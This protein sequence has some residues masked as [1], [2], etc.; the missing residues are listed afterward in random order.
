MGSDSN[1]QF[2]LE[3]VAVPGKY[4]LDKPGQTYTCGRGKDNEIVCL[5][6]TVSR[7]HCMFFHTKDEVYVTDLESSNGVYINGVAAKPLQ[8]TKLQ[9]NDIIGIGCATVNV[10]DSS[11]FVYKLRAIS[12]SIENNDSICT[13]SETESNVEKV[14]DDKHNGVLKR[15]WKQENLDTKVPQSKIPKLDCENCVPGQQ[16]LEG[17]CKSKDENDI[18][19]IH[20]S[21]NNS[22][23]NHSD[24]SC[25]NF[26]SHIKSNSKTNINKHMDTTT[27]ETSN[28]TKIAKMNDNSFDSMR[29]PVSNVLRENV[30]IDE[31]SNTDSNTKESN[32]YT[33][34]EVLKRPK[35]KLSNTISVQNK[36]SNVCNFESKST[37][38]NNNVKAETS[39]GT[40]HNSQKQTVENTNDTVIPVNESEAVIDKKTNSLPLSPNFICTEDNI[41]KMEEELQ[42]TDN[43]ENAIINPQ[44]LNSLPIISPI[45]LKKV[46]EQPKTTF[47]VDD[48]V[49]LSDSEDDIFPCSQLF[50]AGYGINTSVK[51]EI[52]EEPI[53]IENERFSI[54]ESADLVI[55]LTDSEDEDNNWLQR[56]SRSQI[57]N[58]DDEIDAE[59]CDIKKEVTDVNDLI[60]NESP[61][62]EE[63]KCDIDEEKEKGKEPE[64]SAHQKECITLPSDKNLS[65]IFLPNVSV[66]RI[67]LDFRYCVNKLAET[68]D[69]VSATTE[70]R[71]ESP[72]NQSFVQKE[73][74]SATSSN[75]EK[76]V[77]SKSKKLEKKVP[78]IEPLHMPTGRRRSSWN[79]TEEVSKKSE[80]SSKSEGSTKPPQRRLSVQE[81][82][83]EQEKLKLE[84]YLHTKEQKNRKMLH[85]WAACLPPS[86]KKPSAPLSKEEK[87][88][89]VDNRKVKLKKLAM[90]KRLSLEDNQGKKRV[91]SKPKAKVTTKTRND[92]LVEE[93][94]SA[95]K[96]DDTTEM[97]KASSSK[98]ITTQNASANV[99]L[100]ASGKSKDASME[101]IKRLQNKLT[102]NDISTL[103]KIPKKSKAKKSDANT[104]VAE[105]ALK[106]LSLEK[107]TK[108][109]NKSNKDESKIKSGPSLASNQKLSNAETKTK[110][111]VSFS[112]TIQTVHVYEI[113]E[114]NVLKKLVGKDAPIPREKVMVTKPAAIAKS[115]NAKYNEF[116]LRIFLWNPVWLEEQMHLKTIAPVVNPDELHLML[117]HY[118]SYDEYYNTIAPLLL[119][120][121][122]YCI[123]KDFQAVDSNRQ[124]TLMCSTVE[125]SVQKEVASPNLHFT[126]LMLEVLATDEDMHKQAHPLFGD[127]VFFEC[128]YNNNKGQAFRKVFAF[129]LDLH[130]TVLTPTTRFNKDLLHYVNKPRTLLTYTMRTRPL[131]INILVNRVQRLRVVTYL[132]PNLRM[133]QALDYLPSSPLMN[134]ILNP[135]LEMYQLPVISESEALI[136]GD[137]LN[138]KQMEAVCKVTKTVVQRDTKLCFIHGPPGTGK[139]KV[140]VNIITQILYGNNRYTSNGSSFKMLVCAPSNAA[141]DEIV[142]RLLN[143]RSSIK[144]DAKLKPFRMVR[145]GRPETMHPTVKDI[146]VTELARRDIRKTTTNSNNISPESIQDEMQF[147]ISKINAIKCELST[148]RNVDEVYK[149]HLK[150]KLDE[151]TLKYEMLRNPRPLNERNDKERMKLQRNAENRILGHADIITCTLSSCCTNQ[152]ESIFGTNKKRISVCI[153]DEA[154]Q[155]CEAETLIPLMLGINTFVLVG[156]HNQLPATILSPEAKKNGLDQSIFSRVQRAFESQ[157]HNPIITLDVQYRMHKD[158]AFWPNKFFY[159]G[160][161]KNEVRCD[162]NFP[163]HAYRMLNMNTNQSNDSFSNDN[164][165]EFVANI[166]YSMFTFANFDKWDSCISYGILTPYNNQKAIIL[167]KIN[168]K[169]SSVPETI[170]KK[171]KIEINT[172]DGFQGQERDVIIMSCVR[173]E[174]I[175]FLADRQRLCVALTRAKHSLIICGNFGIFMG[176]DMEFVV[177]RRKNPPDLF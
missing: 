102:I 87:K 116:L 113:D 91:L 158:I 160:Q 38:Q 141:I 10:T 64:Q 171:M 110:K 48:V 155:S 114:S 69:T 163:F 42:L 150:I 165:A 143:I 14:C 25:A 41:I 111:R 71:L 47:S 17:R 11:M 129:V 70:N 126:T 94:I 79:K 92:F 66:E 156:D 29:P 57:L 153:V 109:T 152:M 154:T 2:V 62:R 26:A 123:T 61:L 139:S 31:I 121:I 68:F 85:K 77:P 119:L 168:E 149:Q 39:L 34:Q 130:I 50:D 146:S 131:D 99:K 174:K 80:N 13:L 81:R 67:D 106:N 95:A 115:R 83:E 33:S 161:L 93:T 73:A 45:K 101:I 56:L 176:S 105:N 127:L 8:M 172:V 59:M 89:L 148:S 54:L 120:E 7:R 97:S 60:A 74:K 128:A 86:K 164:E 75:R 122:W 4:V 159:G 76:P 166:V 49:N 125:N 78:Q 22:S 118:R 96:V 52:K 98:S 175:G 16:P 51:D 63:T 173:S 30:N 12:Q 28:S 27:F 53:K 46:Q 82:K 44:H 55:S 21:L 108:T 162:D 23:M 134:L 88:M 40:T 167:T 6:L 157:P 103:G 132:R 15:K 35:K 1:W 145:I 112:P 72:R 3:R 136:T 151:M 147:L 144:Q 117:T 20:A 142:L 135:K 169:I 107:Q 177:I 104:A 100:T 24:A 32:T 133:V 170:K 138:T 18:E 43:D 84:E 37:M 36:T 140:I 5:S 9:P 137:Q 58:E 19:I 65:Q 90:E 124:R